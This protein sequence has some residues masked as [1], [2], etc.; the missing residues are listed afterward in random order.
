[1]IA[2]GV[3]L[4]RCQLSRSEGE[5]ALRTPVLSEVLVPPLV[6]RLMRPSEWPFIIFRLADI[7]YSPVLSLD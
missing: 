5:G 3:L 7:H 2:A 6:P 1:M 4:T